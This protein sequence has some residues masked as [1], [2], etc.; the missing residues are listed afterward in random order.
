MDTKY[1]F[2]VHE[3]KLL[4]ID[5]IHT[6][7]SSR[8]YYLDGYADRQAKGLPQKQLS[9]EFVRVVDVQG[10]QGKTGEVMPDMPDEFVL[11]ISERYIELYQLITGKEF[12]REN[13]ENLTQRIENNVN[14]FLENHL[15]S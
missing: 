7:D 6:P 12:I 11:E 8:Y 2:G 10:F 1:E 9:K 4:L 3:G 15:S 5:E 14:T 13:Q